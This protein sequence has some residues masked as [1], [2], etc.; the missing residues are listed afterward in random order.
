MCGIFAIFSSTENKNIGNEIVEGLKRLQH[1]GKDGYGIAYHACGRFH[2]VK[3]EGRVNMKELP[4]ESRCCVGHNRYS[5]SGYTIDNGIIVENELQPLKGTVKSKTYYL[6]HNGNIPSADGHDTSRLVELIDSLQHMDIEEILTFIVRTIPAAF[7]LILLFEDRLYVVRDRYGIRP[8]CLGQ[9]NGNYY[10]SSESHGL[11]DASFIGDVKPGEVIRI[12]CHGIT[13][14]FLHPARQLSLCTFEILY[15]ANENSVIDGYSVKEIRKGLAIKLAERENLVGD[16]Y[17][18]VGVPS[19]GR[20]LG[21]TYANIAG[22]RYGQWITKNPNVDRTFI[23]K[24]DRERKE[25]CM[26][27]FFY[28]IPNLRGSKVILVDDTIVRGNV[29]SAIIENL[30]RIGV[31]EIHVR[32][33]APPVVDRCI[34]G[35]SIQDRNELIFTNRTLGEVSQEIGA[36]TLSYLS[37]DDVTEL[38]PPRSYNLCFSGHVD[39]DIV[40]C[41]RDILKESGFNSDNVPPLFLEH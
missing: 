21:Q 37:L 12:N 19:T 17:V 30:R 13:S 29:I 32:I 25:A 22:F 31:D 39:K 4:I 36:D 5:T 15:F 27:K 24:T 1:R 10:V 11:G 26:K 35:I 41:S 23:L 18:V 38:V 14:I 33:P 16:D 3:K 7:C 9:R 20:L 8:M 40:S 28:D 2:A 6:V 34:L